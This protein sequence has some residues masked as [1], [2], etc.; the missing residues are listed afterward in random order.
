MIVSSKMTKHNFD[1]SDFFALF[2]EFDLVRDFINSD[3]H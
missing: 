2:Q 1:R 3:F